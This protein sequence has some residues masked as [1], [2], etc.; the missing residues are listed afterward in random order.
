M[1]H[2]TS[3]VKQKLKIDSHEDELAEHYIESA[4]ESLKLAGVKEQEGALYKNA[5]LI[6]VLLDYENQDKDLNVGALNNALQSITLKLKDHGG[7]SIE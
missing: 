6:Q 4:K 3:L 2:L 7:E 1:E 5:V